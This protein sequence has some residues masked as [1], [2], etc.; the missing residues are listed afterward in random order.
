[1]KSLSR[2]I[3]TFLPLIGFMSYARSAT[4]VVD[5]FDQASYYTNNTNNFTQSVDLPLANVRSPFLRGCPL[6]GGQME[7]TL[8]ATAGNVSLIVSGTPNGN[9]SFCAPLRLGLAYG[10]NVMHDI[11]GYTGFILNFSNMLGAGSMYVEVGGQES[12]AQVNR[13]NLIGTGDFFYPLDRVYENV[14]FTKDSFNI[15]IFTFEATSPEFS[16]TLD[17]IRLVPEASSSAL[18]GCALL[19][20]GFRRSRR[21]GGSFC[22][23]DGG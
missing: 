18:L 11:T 14:G 12:L 7:S 10:D 4:L 13:I 16:F 23:V 17:E 8:D 22:H 9:F 20:V 21:Q 19:L 6:P 15:L 2:L 5:T 3:I 1:M